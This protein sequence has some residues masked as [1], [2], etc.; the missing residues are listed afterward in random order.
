MIRKRFEVQGMHCVGCT[1]AV[2]GA[3]ERID[4]VQA[5]SANYARQYVDVE[6]DE[7]R[8]A[9]EQI[10]AAVHLAG[11]AATLPGLEV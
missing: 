5:A 6:F 3:I 10:V 7:S 1:M 8:V 11:Y 4:G 9:D 2:E